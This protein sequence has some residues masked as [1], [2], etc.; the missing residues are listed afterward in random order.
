[1]VLVLFRL[2]FL[3]AAAFHRTGGIWVALLAA[4]AVALGGFLKNAETS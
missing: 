3:P 2:I 4:A 1:L